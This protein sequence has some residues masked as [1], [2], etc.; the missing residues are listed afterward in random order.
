MENSRKPK[1]IGNEKVPGK[2]EIQ[3]TTQTKLSI[4][5]TT[6]PEHRSIIRINIK[7]HRMEKII[8][9]LK[10]AQTIAV[11][12]YWL[13]NTRYCG[14]FLHM[15]WDQLMM[16]KVSKM[17]EDTMRIAVFLFINHMDKTTKCNLI[18]GILRNTIT[19]P[20]VEGRIIQMIKLQQIRLIQDL[21]KYSKAIKA[22]PFA[23]RHV[24]PPHYTGWHL[25]RREMHSASGIIRSYD[26]HMRI[27]ARNNER[28]NIPS[29]PQMQ[30]P[31]LEQASTA[32]KENPQ[33]KT[34]IEME[35]TDIE[36]Q[37]AKIDLNNSQ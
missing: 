22:G 25:V 31:Q 2:K 5:Q 12:N 28:G 4:T 29:L 34:D 17:E 24:K 19:N 14:T 13:R 27:S 10:A 3:R 35:D 18:H 36:S 6:P 23:S 15:P 32:N 20:L 1:K 37:M 11:A 21:A 26:A 7:S 30:M 33:E 8:T 9:P 16:F